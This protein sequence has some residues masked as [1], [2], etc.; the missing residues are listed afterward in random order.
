MRFIPDTSTSLFRAFTRS[1]PKLPQRN[2]TTS[3][4]CESSS[5]CNENRSVTLAP[6]VTLHVAITHA[7]EDTVLKKD[8]Q[9]AGTTSLAYYPSR[10]FL[11]LP[12]RK[13]V[14]TLLCVHT[15]ENAKLAIAAGNKVLAGS[16]HQR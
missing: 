12:G 2:K 11:W 9:G 7:G 1:I 8:L 10:L 16:G 6:A 5:C 13:D 14:H 15:L 4:H 3:G